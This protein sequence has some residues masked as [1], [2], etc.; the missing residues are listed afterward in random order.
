MFPTKSYFIFIYKYFLFISA[1]NSIQTAQVQYIIDNV[2]TELQKNE[3]RRFIY[4]EVAFFYR[5]WNEQD[6]PTR[7]VVKRLVNE[8]I[9]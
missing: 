3:D 4:V 5:W 9:I 1:N 7:H 2:V 6:D 8:G